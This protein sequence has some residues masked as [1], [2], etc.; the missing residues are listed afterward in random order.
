M[1]IKY[2]KSVTADLKDLLVGRWASP[3]VCNAVTN[4]KGGTYISLN[5][6]QELIIQNFDTT[7]STFTNETII[8]RFEKFSVDGKN[9]LKLSDSDSYNIFSLKQNATSKLASSPK[10]VWL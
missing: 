5:N 9:L 4:R 2:N 6:N 10:Q 7:S 1:E 8:N 3:I